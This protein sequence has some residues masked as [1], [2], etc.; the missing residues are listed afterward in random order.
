VQRRRRPSHGSLACQGTTV[1]HVQTALPTLRDRQISPHAACVAS[2]WVTTQPRRLRLLPEGNLPRS[3]HAEYSDRPQLCSPARRL[4]YK[5]AADTKGI[6][7]MFRFRRTAIWRLGGALLMGRSVAASRARTG[8][9]T[10]AASP[11][12]DSPPL[13]LRKGADVHLVRLFA[14]N[15][16]PGFEKR[17]RHQG[18]RFFFRHQ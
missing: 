9:A 8:A 2:L 3:R 10:V 16:L 4:R 1:A 11:A 13:R 15:A 17:T 5:G 6:C 18:A 14:P 12:P 7:L